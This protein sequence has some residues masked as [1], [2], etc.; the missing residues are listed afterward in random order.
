MFSNKEKTFGSD[1]FS[2]SIIN[3]SSSNSSKKRKKKRY[4]V[5]PVKIKNMKKKRKNK[6]SQKIKKENQNQIQK[7]Y[8]ICQKCKYGINFR[9]NNAVNFSCNCGRGEN[10]S[11]K[12]FKK[13][14]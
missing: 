9:I 12:F 1:Y 4:I 5:Y 14:I 13:I 3:S 11:L 2:L 7:K 8:I 10:K 6:K